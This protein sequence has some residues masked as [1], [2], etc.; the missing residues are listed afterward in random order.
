VNQLPREDPTLAVPE[1]AVS[2][3]HAA[4]CILQVGG[5]GLARSDGIAYGDEKR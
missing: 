1:V 3:V 2:E 4:G 5:G